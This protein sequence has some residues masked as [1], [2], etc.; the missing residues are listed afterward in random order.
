MMWIWVPGY[1]AEVKNRRGLFEVDD[2]LGQKLLDKGLA[3]DP[4]NGAAHLSPISNERLTEKVV[5]KRTKKVVEPETVEEVKEPEAEE[6][7]ES[8]KPEKPETE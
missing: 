1:V 2:K 5:K 7:S 8:E 6:A 4:R 3:E